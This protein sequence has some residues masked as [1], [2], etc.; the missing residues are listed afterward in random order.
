MHAVIGA[1]TRQL[2]AA[3]C[4]ETQRHA[5]SKDLTAAGCG[6]VAA[7][8]QDAYMNTAMRKGD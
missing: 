6:P 7:M 5:A 2:S 3:G 1:D 8:L 4:P